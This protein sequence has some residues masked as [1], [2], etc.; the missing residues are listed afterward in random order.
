LTT[1]IS[2]GSA[3]T[4]LTGG[5]SFSSSFLRRSF[6]N[7]TVKKY[8]NW[9]TFAEVITQMRVTYFFL[10]HGVQRRMLS[11][12]KKYNIYMLSQWPICRRQNNLT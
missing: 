11:V 5:G 3:T 9:F 1:Y 6:L 12:F 7:L 8:E 2:Q 10:S 4:D